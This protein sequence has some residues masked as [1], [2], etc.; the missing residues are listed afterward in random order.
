MQNY[1]YS[2]F[3]RQSSPAPGDDGPGQSVQPA[4]RPRREEDAGQSESL[5]PARGVGHGGAQRPRGQTR[6]VLLPL[7]PEGKYS[8][9]NRTR[10][11]QGILS[12]SS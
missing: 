10:W 2:A 1:V 6:Q 5:G 4:G 8:P 3:S 9:K 7:R 11:S 12:Q